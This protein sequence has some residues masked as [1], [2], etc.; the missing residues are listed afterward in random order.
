MVSLEHKKGILST[1]SFSLILSSS[2]PYKLLKFEAENAIVDGKDK[3]VFVALIQ[4]NDDEQ[5]YRVVVENI[6]DKNLA[7]K[8]VNSWIAERE[9]EDAARIAE[10]ENDAKIAAEDENLTQLNASLEA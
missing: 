6:A 5:P 1:L 8:E 4:Q 3:R 9:R 10:Q 7:M 2:M